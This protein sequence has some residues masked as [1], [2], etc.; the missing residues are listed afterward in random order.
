MSR[1]YRVTGNATAVAS[2]ANTELL[3]GV[4]LTGVVFDVLRIDIGQTTTQNLTGIVVKLRRAS[5]TVTAA[6]GGTAITPTKIDT[7][8]SSPASTSWVLN[9]TAMTTTG[10]F[11]DLG[12]WVMQDVVGLSEIPI[13]E[14]VPQFGPS[15]GMQILLVTALGATTNMTCTVT[16]REY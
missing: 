11:T 5:A 7:G 9:G 14:D 15:E 8:D 2:A 16:I 4:A 13:P 6:S 12:T 1:I 10:A 3:S